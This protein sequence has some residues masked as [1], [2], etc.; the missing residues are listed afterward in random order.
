MIDHPKI[1]ITYNIKLALLPAFG[2]FFNRPPARS[3][4]LVPRLPPLFL[5]LE[6][7]L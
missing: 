2:L 7:V 5:F 6:T 4:T 3:H 1:R